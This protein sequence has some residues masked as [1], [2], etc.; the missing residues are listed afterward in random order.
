MRALERLAFR[1]TLVLPSALAAVAATVSVASEVTVSDPETARKAVRDAAPGDVVVLA[2][3][4]WRD[5]DLRLDGEGTAEKPVVIRAE[6][7]GET[8]FTGA[9]RIRLGGSHLV[10]SGLW[11]R[12][13]AGARSDWLEFRID[14]KRRANHCRLTDCALTE[15]PGFAAGEEGNRWIGIYGE[16]N[17]VDRCTLYGKKNEGATLVVWLGKSDPGRHRI[18]ANRFGERPRLGRNGG[19]TIRIGDSRTSMSRAECLVEGN[20]FFRCDGETEC[21][22]NKS[23]GNVYRG[24]YFVETRGTLTLRHGND[25]LVEGNWFLG[26]NRAR[27]GGIRVIGEGHR[28][29]GNELRGLEGDGFR[30]AL[31]L[32][33]GI[34]ESPDHGYHQV[35]GALF[36][37]NRVHDCKE[38]LLIGYNDVESATLPPSGVRFA[39]NVIVA[40]EGRPAVK[41]TA[42][43]EE[44]IW[45]GNAI[46]GE[47]IG[48]EPREGGRELRPDDLAPAPEPGLGMFGASWLGEG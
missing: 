30:S 38:P 20:L 31:C 9:S 4:E 29:V 19:E 17:Q 44:T 28:V 26:R 45:E 10:V 42:V 5:V 8:V 43:P 18:L 7:P 34:P 27:T 15:D 47:W 13:L 12:N 11:L 16:G 25:C 41:A 40:R 21:I 3:G 48:L 2:A 46:R 24:N 39:G 1:S 35:R 36:E 37:G 14:S 6:R 23:G 33:N 32:V 22:S